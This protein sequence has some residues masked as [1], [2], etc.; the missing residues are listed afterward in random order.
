[1]NI[2]TVK[3]EIKILVDDTKTKEQI[4]LETIHQIVSGLEIPIA[5]GYAEI[6][7]CKVSDLRPNEPPTNKLE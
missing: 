5:S 6:V 3:C 7:C 1:M 2:A 4:A